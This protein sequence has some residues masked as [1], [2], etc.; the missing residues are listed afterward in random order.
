[1]R[2][3]RPDL[4]VMALEQIIPQREKADLSLMELEQMIPLREKPL[5]GNYASPETALSQ[6]FQDLEK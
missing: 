4:S 2:K 6:L 3:K 5:T 1:M